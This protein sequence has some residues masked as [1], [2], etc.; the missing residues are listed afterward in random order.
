MQRYFCEKQEHQIFT[1][2]E[3]DSY[4]V[5]KVMRMEV[6]NSI[7]IICQN[8]TYL[9]EIV[10]LEP[11]VKAKIVE[12][13]EEE[14][15]LSYQITIV[16][17]LVKEQK[18]DM[19]LQK[20]T[21]LGV[22]Q[23]IPYEATRSILKLDTK[24]DKKI[25]RWQKVVKEAA[26]QS[27]RKMIPVV[28]SCMNLSNLVKLSDYDMKILCTVNENSQN[29][30]KVLSKVT[31]G[32]KILFVIGPEGGFTKEEEKIFLENQFLPISLGKT[33]LRTETASL[34]IM[35]VIRYLDLG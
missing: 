3:D 13:I 8:H 35:S 24:Q 32:A 33:V 30:K 9:C 17:S 12:L 2:S 18:M 11:L 31:S 27:K 1:L 22:F 14:R 5:V 20:C 7:E 29:L 23:I 10:E 15:E 34:F 16:Q 19:I 25:M 21:E 26:E 4:H 6:S 28:T